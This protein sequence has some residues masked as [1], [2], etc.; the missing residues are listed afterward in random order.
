MG[1]AHRDIIDGYIL[2]PE[3]MDVPCGGILESGAVKKNPFTVPDAH[4]DG[5]EESLD[6]VLVKIIGSLVEGAG[7][8]ASLLVTLVGVPGLAVIG[9][10][11]APCKDLLPLVAANLGLL[12]LAPG[13]T[14]AVDGSLSGD[15][16]VGFTIGMDGRKAT[17]N[18]K[19]LEIG[20]YYR[21]KVFIAGKNDDGV[22]G[23]M[24]LRVGLKADGAGEPDAVG[25]DELAA[26]PGFER[27]KSFCKSIRTEESAVS[28]SAEISERHLA[29]R[30]GRKTH[31]I[32]FERKVLRSGMQTFVSPGARKGARDS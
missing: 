4:K 10:N 19:A 11:A 17:A 7:G 30:D 2:A 21:V 27:F 1:I 28:D 15:G 31:F 29:R 22:I 6:K 16:D 24:K 14:A 20:I 32:H 23:K 13:V 25:N 18:V 12:H 3:G 26:A 8:H 9:K 5:T